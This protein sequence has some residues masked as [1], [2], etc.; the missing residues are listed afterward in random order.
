MFK[1]NLKT[2][3]NEKSNKNAL[4]VLDCK[5]RTEM[6]LKKIKIV[7]INS[8]NRIPEIKEFQI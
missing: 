3:G 7:L 8:R 1:K 6:E 2:L 5:G 4:I